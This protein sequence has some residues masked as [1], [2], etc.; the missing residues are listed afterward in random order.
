MSADYTSATQQQRHDWTRTEIRAL[1]ELPFMDLM[2]QAQ[3]VHRQHFDPNLVQMST[4]LS[5]KTGACPDH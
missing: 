3:S 1:F 5:I 4:L 2:F